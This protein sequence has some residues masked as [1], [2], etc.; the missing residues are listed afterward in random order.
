MKNSKSKGFTLIELIMVTIILG[1]LAAVAA[2]RYL[3]SVERA[4]EA[5]ER[6]VVD[7]L[8]AAAEAYAT[9]RFTTHGRYDYPDNPFDL[10]Q[11]DGYVGHHDFDRTN[12]GDGNW[13][14][15][16]DAGWLI[17]KHQRR[18]NTI[19]GWTYSNLDRK[20][21]RAD[22]RGLNVGDHEDAD[23]I[24]NGNGD[25][26]DCEGRTEDDPDFTGHCWSGG[27]M[28]QSCVNCWDNSLSNNN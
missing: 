14:T 17:I 28:D 19:Y 20:D 16:G 2:P 10:V 27:S 8:R 26:T 7:E 3:Q 9:D 21:D 4:E 13:W 24:L 25:H 23:P 1:I 6:R 11:V 5:V 18:D 22:D 12:M 15:E